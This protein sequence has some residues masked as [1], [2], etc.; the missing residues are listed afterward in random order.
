MVACQLIRELTFFQWHKIY[1]ISTRS[2]GNMVKRIEE[3]SNADTITCVSDNPKYRPFEV[4]KE[5]IISVALVVGSVRL[6]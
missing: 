6:E 1:V 5:E 3:G 4:L 2:Q